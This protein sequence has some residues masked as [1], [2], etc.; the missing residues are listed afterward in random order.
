MDRETI[1]SIISNTRN[2]GSSSF[3]KQDILDKCTIALVSIE[4][5]KD[6]LFIYHAN[7]WIIFAD[8]GGVEIVG[9]PV[10]KVDKGKD[11]VGVFIVTY[12]IAESLDISAKELFLKALDNTENEEFVI[13]SLSSAVGLDDDGYAYYAT[14]EDSLYGAS[15]LLRSDL[16]KDFAEEKDS[17]LI[18]VPSSVH[19]VIIILQKEMQMSADDI[20]DL[21]GTVRNI[22]RTTLRDDDVL[23]DCV[24]LYKK[25]KDE[26]YLISHE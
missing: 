23:A 24:F 20:I 1:N 19:E 7:K 15:F 3:T 2:Y 13:K 9:V 16:I 12:E 18:I 25:G 6:A 8:D 11:G 17:D 22:N 10:V 4:A 21:I 14:T 26:L 5:A